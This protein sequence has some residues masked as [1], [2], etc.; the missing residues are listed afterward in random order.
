MEGVSSFSWRLVS[1]NIL[2]VLLARELGAPIRFRLCSR[3]T[4]HSGFLGSQIRSLSPSQEYYVPTLK[5]IS[6]NWDRIDKIGNRAQIPLTLVGYIGWAVALWPK[7]VSIVGN[8]KDLNFW[9]V[10]AMLFLLLGLLQAAVQIWPLPRHDGSPTKSPLRLLPNG[11]L[12]WQPTKIVQ[13]ANKSYSNATVYLDNMT[14][15]NCQFEHTTFVYE[16][17]GPFNMIDCQL[18]R[19]DQNEV[20]F[21]L[22]S[23]NPIVIAA[24]QL[25]AKTVQGGSGLKGMRFE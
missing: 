5:R 20:N 7:N 19:K 21:V 17:T 14:F 1:P 22:R 6:M 12:T 8:P 16:G 13:I 15:I 24:F 25:Q 4:S 10:T 23:G 9:A 2:A 3:A 18:V 11:M